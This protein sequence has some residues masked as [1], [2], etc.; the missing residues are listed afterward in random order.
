MVGESSLLPNFFDTSTVVASPDDIFSILEA[1]EG[2]SD[3]FTAFT[4]PDCSAKKDVDHN[5]YRL[6][7]QKSTSN[8]SGVQELVEA[9]AAELETA[10]SPKSK[11]H[12]VVSPSPAVDQEGCENSN[13]I[14]MSHVTVERN[15]TIL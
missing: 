4:P 14:K 6:A 11:K 5:L 10:F 2:V 7:S 13:G 3:D 9:E 12:K 15:R 8:S 1:L